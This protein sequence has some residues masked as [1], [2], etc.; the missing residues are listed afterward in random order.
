MH[1]GKCLS[2]CHPVPP[3]QTKKGASYKLGSEK[4]SIDYITLWATLTFRPSLHSVARFTAQHACQPCLNLVWVKE[5]HF[6]IFCCGHRFPFRS[7]PVCLLIF[8]INQQLKLFKLIECLKYSYD[9]RISV[10]DY[11]HEF[12]CSSVS[13]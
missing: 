9:Y 8:F 12:S 10:I 7:N 11:F 1:F 6:A 3:F 4:C 2:E 5:L 13:E